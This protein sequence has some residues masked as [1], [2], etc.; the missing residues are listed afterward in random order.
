MV[1]CGRRVGTSSEGNFL[2][3]VRRWIRNVRL[4]AAEAPWWLLLTAVATATSVF[5]VLYLLHGH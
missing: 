4:D 2:A 5:A 1:T 3:R